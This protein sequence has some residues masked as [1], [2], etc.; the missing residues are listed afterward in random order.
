[1]N[2]TKIKKFY[3]CTNFQRV[4]S[5]KKPIFTKVIGILM[6]MLGSTIFGQRHEIGIRGGGTS[7]VGDIGN[8]NYIQIPKLNNFSEIGAP[9]Y[10]G[11]LYRMNFNP[12]QTL[13]FNLGYSQIPFNDSH[14]KEEY[15][16]NRRRYGSNAG[17]DAEV[18]FE[19]NFFPV[20]NEQKGM[21]SPYIFGGVGASLYSVRQITFQDK[22]E[23]ND[24]LPTLYDVKTG[25]YNTTNSFAK[26]LS[27]S[28]P[29]GVG[30]K[31]KFNY[32]WAVSAEAMFRPMFTDTVDYSVIDEK[33]TRVNYNRNNAIYSDRS[34][35]PI[36]VEEAKRQVKEYIQQNNVGNKNSND[37]VN[38][39]SLGITYSF[40]RPPCYCD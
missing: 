17:M 18:L 12:Y 23:D 19:Y 22:A 35:R 9:V 31:Y 33:D 20:N 38:T 24:L 7:M 14:T 25:V 37:W 16:K 10:L 21:L 36:Y 32:N 34:S 2:F 1:M 28:I 6:I 29:F 13:R 40:G 4:I 27:F 26:K 15:R 3:I 5:K 8:A 11:L 39:V 30:L